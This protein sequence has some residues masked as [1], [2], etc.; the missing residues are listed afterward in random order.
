[1]GF[2]H[3][4]LSAVLQRSRVPMEP[5]RFEPDWSDRPRKGKF[6]PGV[7]S[8]PLPDAGSLTGATLE[9]GLYPPPAMPESRFSLPLLGDMLLHS[10]GLTGRRLGVQSNSDLPALPFYTEANWS[11][12]TASG[13]ALYPV[14]TYWVSGPGGPMTPGVHHYSTTHHTMERL[15]TGDVSGIVRDTLGGLE[16]A[17][18]TDQFLVLGVKYW[19]NSFKYNSFCYHVVSMDV[20]ALL[21]TWRLWARARGLRIEPALWFDE[22]ELARLLGLP[23]GEE[24]VFAV[25][26]LT[27]ERPGATGGAEPVR[28]NTLPTGAGAPAA[29]RAAPAAKPPR[30]DNR[31]AAATVRQLDSE[32]SRRTQRFEAVQRMHEATLDGATDRPEPTALAPAAAT[33]AA[34]G[35]GRRSLPAPLSVGMEVRQALRERRSSFGRFD[36]CRPM[37]AEELSTVL[38]A[39]AAVSLDSDATGVG[40]PAL[41]KIYAFVNHVRD[42]EPAVYAYD[43]VD[44]DLRIVRPGNSG[45]F[46]QRNYF[47]SN[48]NLEQAGAVIVPTIR[49]EAVLDAVGDRGYR[50]V[51]AT[52]GALAQ[53][54][55]TVAAALGLG[56]GVALGF[57]NCSY[58]EELGLSGTGEAPLLITMIGREDQLAADVRYEIA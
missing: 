3:D 10:Y 53:T 52:V 12:G 13:G 4:Y 33:N 26:P 6:Y 28:R 29:R 51:N 15:L 14:S 27:W 45:D 23:D 58:I 56:G 34:A 5:T 46:L 9:Q 49:A 1:M 41:L 39:L 30:A 7:D 54:L 31:P 2:A 22:R 43:S 17:Q 20:G 36:A 37:R 21:Q 44:R 38:S 47:L 50:L 24:G 57:D 11:R 48:Y 19:T 18:H 16:A 40:G 25:I 32:R 35:M 55:Y 8:F 42:I